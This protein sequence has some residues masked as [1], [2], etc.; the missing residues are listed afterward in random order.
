MLQPMRKGCTSLGQECERPCWV[1]WEWIRRKGY[2]S[3]WSCWKHLLLPSSP[4]PAMPSIPHSTPPQNTYVRDS[5]PTT[6]Q[7]GPRDSAI[8]ANE[9]LVWV[10]RKL[11]KSWNFSVLQLTLFYLIPEYLYSSFYCF[12]PTKTPS[13]RPFT[14]LWLISTPLLKCD[15]C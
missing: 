2:M 11:G 13:I 9:V 4:I 6:R 8:F 7:G 5:S 10:I 15:S 3:N 12:L 1:V 14:A